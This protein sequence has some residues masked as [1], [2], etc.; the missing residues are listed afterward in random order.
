[1]SCRRACRRARRR[2][3]PTARPRGSGSELQRDLVAQ[4]GDELL[5]G[6]LGR[7]AGGLA[8][9]AAARHPRPPPPPPA[10]IDTSTVPWVARSET[11]WRRAPASESS[12]RARAATFVPS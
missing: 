10:M 2:P 8:V 12:S 4:E 1:M 9:P 3:R 5:V 7:E 11:F 6:E